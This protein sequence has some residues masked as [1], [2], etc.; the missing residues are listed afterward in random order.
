MRHGQANKQRGGVAI[1]FS[2]L[3]VALTASIAAAIAYDVTLDTRRTQS[4]LLQE[5]ARLIALGAEDWISD[6]LRQDSIDTEADH[7]GELWAQDLPPLPIEGAG[8]QGVITGQIIDLQS[9]FNLN[10]LVDGNG[11][12]VVL[13]VERLKR[14]LV[15]LGL[16]PDVTDAIAD[17]I[18]G[19]QDFSFPN[20]AEDDVYTSRIPA[21]RAGNQAF[22]SVN[23]LAIVEGID[24]AAMDLLRPHI[25]A[26]PERTPLNINTAT[27][28]V[29]MALDANVT[30]ADAEE[31]AELR[32]E[33][34]FD[35]P[36][37]ELAGLVPVDVIDTLETETRYFEL[38][39]VVRIGTVR[40]TMYSL[41]YR[42][43]QGDI[44]TVMRSFGSSL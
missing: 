34:G 17:W 3:I 31:L 33:N 41:L 12:L 13:E 23:E 11:E 35:D 20:G 40:F 4:L 15:N 37:V 39:S 5:Q 26:L 25:T 8:M 18:D 2:L 38:R 1:L 7:L 22:R 43:E 28:A 14:L 32:F 36:A 30:A 21:L 6:I 19:D 9:K 24:K 44:A 10:N 29:M 27:P 42:S 16:S